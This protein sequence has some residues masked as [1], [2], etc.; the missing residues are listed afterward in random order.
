MAQPNDLSLPV[1]EEMI[2][3]V[4]FYHIILQHLGSMLLT[5]KCWLLWKNM[6]LYIRKTKIVRM[7]TICPV[8]TGQIIFGHIHTN[9]RYLK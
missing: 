2:E 8:Q 1:P 5:I 7:F 3:K 9:G 6:Q 4:K